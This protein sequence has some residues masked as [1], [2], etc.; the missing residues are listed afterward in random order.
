MS[1]IGFAL[2]LARAVLGRGPVNYS[3]LVP[4]DHPEDL[5]AFEAAID[6]NPLEATNHLVLA[7]YLQENAQTPEDA[8]QAEFRR[9]MGRWIGNGGLVFDP[10]NPRISRPWGLQIRLPDERGRMAEHRRNPH[11]YLPGGVEFWSGNLMPWSQEEEDAEGGQVAIPRTQGS[12]DMDTGA[13][14]WYEYR[15]LERALWSGYL[16]W[17]DHRVAEQKKRREAEYRA[18]RR[19]LRR[20]S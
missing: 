5:A 17:L 15:D 7:D 11:I 1:D 3:Q 12:I 6:A 14:R 20:R 19:S 10:D 8:H 2:D 9:S 16:P 18:H 4:Y 13:A